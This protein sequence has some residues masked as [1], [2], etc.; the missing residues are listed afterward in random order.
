[1]AHPWE[2]QRVVVGAGELEGGEGV[3][4]QDEELEM[5]EVRLDEGRA[6]VGRV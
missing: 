6:G 1:M 4:R 5:G 3:G 2:G